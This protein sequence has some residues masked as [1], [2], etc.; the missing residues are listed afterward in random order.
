LLE[1]DLRVHPGVITV[2]DNQTIGNDPD[3]QIFFGSR[4]TLPGDIEID[5]RLRAIDDLDLPHIDGYVEADARVGWQVAEGLEVFVVGN[6]L[7]ESRHAETGELATLRE[8]RRGVSIGAR[9][10][11]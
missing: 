6:N 7:L 3:Y 8:V 5:V 4:M 1:K 2:A 11:F 9:W 10:R